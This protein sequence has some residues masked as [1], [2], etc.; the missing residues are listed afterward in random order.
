[1]PRKRLSWNDEEAVLPVERAA[2]RRSAAAPEHPATPDEGP[3]HPAHTPQPGVH[4]HENGDTSSWA[5]D[6]VPGPYPSSAHPATPDEGAAHPAHE[7]GRELPP[8]AGRPQVTNEDLGV[9]KAAARELLASVERKAAKCVRI[10]ELTLGAKATTAAIEDHAVTLMDLDDSII[11]ATLQRLA[12]DEDEDEDET[13]AEASEDE[14]EAEESDDEAGKKA[15]DDALLRRLLAEED[16][17]DDE[18]ESDAESGKKAESEHT[19]MSQVLAELRSLRAELAALKSAGDDEDEDDSETDAEASSSI[20]ADLETLL[21]EEDEHDEEAEIAAMLEEVAES[22]H[23]APEVAMDMDFADA[24]LDVDMTPMDDPMFS[25]AGLDLDDDEEAIMAQIFAEQSGTSRLA[26]DDEDAVDA[27]DEADAEAGKKASSRTAS[28]KP[29]PRKPSNGATR[30]A[31]VQVPAGDD[32]R[33]LE[34]LWPTA[35]DVSDV[36]K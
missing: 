35:P 28:Q 6:P 3:G 13:D 21:A 9:S 24:G 2:A 22:Y 30:L 14:D 12:E 31:S 18:D 26:G 29:R 20:E 27:E 15:S 23:E 4:D 11:N 10:A 33:E 1:M 34:A 7:G 8:S 5:E 19:A 17:D 16:M 25:D 36:F 32:I